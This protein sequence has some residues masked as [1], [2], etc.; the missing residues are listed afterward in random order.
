MDPLIPLEGD[1]KYAGL[2][3]T[4]TPPGDQHMLSGNVLGT[5]T[6][7][8]PGHL[9]AC[10]NK[11]ALSL[12]DSLTEVLVASSLDWQGVR[13]LFTRWKRDTHSFAQL[14]SRDG[15]GTRKSNSCSHSLTPSVRRTLFERESLRIASHSGI[16]RKSRCRGGESRC[17]DVDGF[18]L[19]PQSSGEFYLP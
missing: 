10:T 3:S 2:L 18:L 17:G 15:I 1:K 6:A 8:L 4:K 14:L 11:C 19:C 9:C 7:I 5:T 12:R 13:P 16:R